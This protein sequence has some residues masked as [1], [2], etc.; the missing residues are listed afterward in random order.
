MLKPL[1]P[2]NIAW[3][4]QHLK[5]TG[6]VRRVTSMPGVGFGAAKMTDDLE[7]VAA[8]LISRTGQMM[9][10]SARSAVLPVLV[11]GTA[12]EEMVGRWMSS[13]GKIRATQRLLRDP[14]RMYGVEHQTNEVKL[15]IQSNIRDERIEDGNFLLNGTDPEDEIRLLES[16]CE[17]F[18][19]A[20]F[21]R[22]KSLEIAS[23]AHASSLTLD[24][25]CIDLRADGSADL[26]HYIAPPEGK[27]GFRPGDPRVASM[28]RELS[29]VIDRPEAA[30]PMIAFVETVF[31]CV[32]GL[33]LNQLSC[34]PSDTGEQK[35]R[36]YFCM[37]ARERTFER[38][39]SSI[40][41]SVA[42]IRTFTAA[43]TAAGASAIPEENVENFISKGE[44]G[45]MCL[46]GIG[47][48]Y[49]KGRLKLKAYVRPFGNTN[50]DGVRWPQ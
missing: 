9:P 28:I 11:Q 50:G 43:A 37:W 47:F 2:A 8:T 20:P 13:I 39:N 15:Y 41:M 10:I 45:E 29:N 40:M 26:K 12:Q 3:L 30:G 44:A 25:L 34:E 14:V 4:E 24:L 22:Q 16:A 7:M 48:E 35:L 36:A 32:P 21:M 18:G 6:T 33:A 1:T 27:S 17:L 49:S 19:V 31:A 23:M 5:S 38:D 42:N 46:D